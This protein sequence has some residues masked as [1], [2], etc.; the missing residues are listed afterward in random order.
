LRFRRQLIVA[1]LLIPTASLLAPKQ[2][3]PCGLIVALFNYLTLLHSCGC[4]DMHQQ[5][6]PALLC[7]NRQL[8]IVINVAECFPLK[9]PFHCCCCNAAQQQLYRCHHL[10]T[11]ID[12]WLT[13]V[14]SESPFCHHTT[15]VADAHATALPLP[16]PHCRAIDF[17]IVI[18]T[19]NVAAVDSL[20][21]SVVIIATAVPVVNIHY[22]LYQ[23]CCLHFIV[24]SAV[25]VDNCCFFSL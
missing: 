16:Q 22:V 14:K 3:L 6:L 24:P 2:T 8:V 20:F 1:F 7:N 18:F 12:S 19:T 23:Q 21:V 5:P 11:A 4:L 17:T 25:G 10:L 13:V 15:A 9:S